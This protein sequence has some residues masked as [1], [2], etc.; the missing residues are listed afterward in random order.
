MAWRL[1]LDVGTNSLGWAA[2]SLDNGRPSGLIGAGVRIFSD[3][4]NPKDGSSLAVQRREPRS[5]RRNRDRYL[6]RRSEFM[7]RLIHHGLMPADDIERKKLETNDPWILRA[8][9][10]K[11]KLSLHEFGRALFHLQQRRGF[12]SNRKTDRADSDKGA[13]AEATQQTKYKLEE[14]NARTLGELFGRPRLETLAQNAE[15]EKGKRKAQPPARVSPYSEKGKMAYDY[16]PT[17]ALIRDEFEQL[18]TA[19][20]SLHGTSL[21]K[22]AYEELADTLFFQR[23]L[24]A[25]PVGKCT[26]DPKQER[27][28]K[29]LP[30]VQ[31]LRIYQEINNLTWRSPGEAAQ[32]LTL[33]Q[34]N[35]VAT[36]LLS[37][38]KLTFSSM[39][40]TV[41][42]LPANSLF[43]LESDKR[44]DLKGDETA[45]VLAASKR[46]GANWRDLS[47]LDQN[48]IVEQLLNEE[49]ESRVVKWLCENFELPEEEARAVADAPLPD[50]H[51]SL[52][53]E[54]TSK[55]LTE[56]EGEP[57]TYDQAVIKAGY[58]SHSQLDHH[59]EILDQL[60]YYGEVLERHV[61]FGTGEPDDHPEKRYGKIANPTVHVALNQIR[62]VL[63]ALI[64]R[65]GPP[66]EI[67]V[68][69]A[70]D[71]P[72]SAKGKSELNRSQ[73][74][75]Q[76]KNDKRRKLLEE[77][78]QP[79][80]Y[81]NRLRLRLWEEL[82]PGNALDRRCPYTG[83]QISIE[84]LFS[85]EVEIEHIL[86][87][88]RT[89][90]DSPANKTLSMREAN[91]YKKER[92]P[93][94]AF[95]ESKDGYVWDNIAERA[96][97]MPPNKSW[98]FAED[99]MGRFKDEDRDFMDRQLRS[100]QYIARLT[101]N[102]LVWL[103]GDP[104]LVW[105]IPGRL[106]SDLR[107]HWGLNSI[108]AGH[109]SEEAQP[110]DVAK[111]RND[112]RHHAL[113][114]IVI[115]L[116]DRSL[117]QAIA[118]ESGKEEHAGSSRLIQELSEPWHGFR[119]AVHTAMDTLIVSHKPDH[120][121]QGALHNDTAYG[122]AGEADKKGKRDVVH[123]VPLSSLAKP[124]K[125][126]LIRDD[127]IREKLIEATLGLSGKDFISALL[128]AGENMQPPV[129]KIRILESMKVIPMRASSGHEYKAYKGDG[130]Y[131]YDIYMGPKGKWTGE[132]ITRYAA[133]QPGFDVTG[134]LS[135]DGKP[136]IMR[137]RGD[138]M[139]AI[140][141]LNQTQ[142]MRIAVITS[143]KVSLAENRES[144]VDGRNRD[145]SDP[146]KY[147]L[148][149]PSRLQKLQARLVHV[150]P[151]GRVFDP[152]PP[153]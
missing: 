39:R 53:R 119:D 33:E 79:D 85:A 140:T 56:L 118:T 89:L 132:V 86:P 62:R 98:R 143:G 136:L 47:L 18:W 101:S 104:K 88:S 76:D 153:K 30:S 51:G 24:K 129:R 3:G 26:L 67:V 110:G 32:K 147:L 52:C 34:R 127:V 92:S 13:I 149:S 152:G 28:P 37:V 50:G 82:N 94:E 73:K 23:P 59:G 151:S 14:E 90:D 54:V 103:V 137:I 102:Y 114:A 148:A 133:N 123:R 15:V 100:T 61:A 99:A 4:R 113:D 11:E 115:A 139:L 120:G 135:T 124:E 29:A 27:A 6:K 105:V 7:E 84:K 128:Q 97:N 77:H 64:K 95:G 80:S 68:E 16:Y 109:N 81:Q 141:E 75:N 138:D 41:L 19:Q 107:H 17:R 117:L 42:K 35:A 57:I 31:R 21:S 142:Y 112:H 78:K 63:N 72:L 122:I 125:L 60:P 116:T 5:A 121:V 46:W 36:K 71:L 8:K 20:K 106:T 108:L 130:N 9:G 96:A 45:A 150:D 43:N 10:L 22:A 1:G 145:K 44:K 66:S 87:R 49:D 55:L 48:R 111:N 38:G 25:Q 70:R 91:R 58:F 69:L 131:C 2:L 144:N 93:H 126:A 40:K 65:Y 83:E 74:T 134:K 146:F 12:Q